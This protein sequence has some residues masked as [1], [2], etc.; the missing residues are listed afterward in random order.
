MMHKNKE[1]I[2]VVFVNR[3]YKNLFEQF[4]F[5]VFLGRLKSLHLTKLQKV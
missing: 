2:I 3:S 4:V 5:A 1:N